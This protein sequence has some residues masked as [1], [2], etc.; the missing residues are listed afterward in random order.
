MYYQ[1]VQTINSTLLSFIVSSFEIFFLSTINH[2][3]NCSM[4]YQVSNLYTATP[5]ASFT[6]I[7]TVHGLCNSVTWMNKWKRKLTNKMQLFWLI[8]LLL[9]N[10]TCV[11]RC[12]RPS[13]GALDCIYS[14]WYWPPLLL[15]A[16][17]VDVMN[18]QVLVMMGEDIAR[19]M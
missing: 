16:G 3:A 19:N 11:G 12:L 15:L 17:V 7:L 8:Y 10:S 9:I 1:V 5:E 2:W 4:K 14:I 18:S 13:S 6:V